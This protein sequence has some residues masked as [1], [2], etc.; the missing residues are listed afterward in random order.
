MVRG[1][2]LTNEL[3]QWRGDADLEGELVGVDAE[4]GEGDGGVSMG[5][6]V[7]DALDALQK[8]VQG[9]RLDELQRRLLGVAE[10][11]PDEGDGQVECVL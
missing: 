2:C 4:V 1:R 10:A 7:P 5:G 11:G 6:V 9:P 8:V 3:G